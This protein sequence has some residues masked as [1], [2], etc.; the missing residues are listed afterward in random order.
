MPDYLPQAGN[1]QEVGRLGSVCSVSLRIGGGAVLGVPQLYYPSATARQPGPLR[2]ALRAPWPAPDL[3]LTCATHPVRA[4]R[5]EQPSCRGPEMG[6]YNAAINKK[7]GQRRLANSAAF[8]SPLPQAGRTL[9]PRP[10]RPA[11]RY[12]HQG[13]RGGCRRWSCG[14]VERGPGGR[15]VRLRGPCSRRSVNRCVSI[16]V[17]VRHTKK[18]I[19]I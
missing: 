8:G 9:L 7:P 3:H 19:T 10:K 18:Y 16:A 6:G 2:L 13:M 17:H 12:G 1:V 5:Y 4:A 15:L 14:H 11:H